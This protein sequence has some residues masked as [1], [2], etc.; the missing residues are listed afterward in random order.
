[1]RSDD[2]IDEADSAQPVG[3]TSTAAPNQ[4]QVAINDIPDGVVVAS[5]TGQVPI[6]IKGVDASYL[7]MQVGDG[8]GRLP[9]GEPFGG[10]SHDQAVDALRRYARA[11]GAQNL[12]LDLR[13]G[14]MRWDGGSVGATVHSSGPYQALH[15]AWTHVMEQARELEEPL[16]T[17]WIAQLQQIAESL[18]VAA[19]TNDLRRMQAL[20]DRLREISATIA[21]TVGGDVS[22]EALSQ[23][24]LVKSPL[25]PIIA[26]NRTAHIELQRYYCRLPKSERRGFSQSE[27][28]FRQQFGVA[29]QN[30]DATAMARINGRVRQLAAIAK[31][32]ASQL[33]VAK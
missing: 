6:Q 22:T 31:A 9:N 17:Q 21:R 15:D 11:R 10:A 4:P 13:N 1:M 19:R 2:Y 30:G 25:V 18:R 8:Y 14:L 12:M 26:D 29:L 27:Q 5:E 7:Y 20:A 16:R 23:A 32:R 3:P 24:R 28:S 33:G